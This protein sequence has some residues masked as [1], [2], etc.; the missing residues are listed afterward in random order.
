MSVQTV[1]SLKPFGTL[2][3]IADEIVFFDVSLQMDLQVLGGDAPVLTS[4]PMTGVP[5]VVQVILHVLLEFVL[6]FESLV[7]TRPI[8]GERSLR[9]VDLSTVR[10][11]VVF[12]ARTVL[13]SG[14][15]TGKSD[16][17][18]CYHCMCP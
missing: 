12:G 9:A 6:H 16:A 14:P 15:I 2:S 13:T 18:M 7:T 11:Q 3:P 10:L 4:G 5:F 8:A 1:L 17:Q